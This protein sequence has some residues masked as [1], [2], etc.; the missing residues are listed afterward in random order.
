M[1][2]FIVLLLVILVL[3]FIHL[4]K[5]RSKKPSNLTFEEYK[6]QLGLGFK[7]WYAWKPEKYSGSRRY[8]KVPRYHQP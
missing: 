1:I 7:P 2:F 6:K 8:T 5:R 3:F 4:Y